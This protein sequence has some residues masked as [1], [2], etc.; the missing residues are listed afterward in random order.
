MTVHTVRYKD[1]KDPIPLITGNEGPDTYIDNRFNSIVEELLNLKSHISSIEIDL[2]DYADEHPKSSD[3]WV[4]ERI[5]ALEDE[6]KALKA[7]K[8]KK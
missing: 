2:R 7:T 1:G 6:V 5:R 4:E 3:Q 8:G